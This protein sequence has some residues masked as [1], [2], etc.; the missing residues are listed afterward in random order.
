MRVFDYYPIYVFEQCLS[1]VPLEKKQH[2]TNAFL[3]FTALAFEITKILIL[4]NRTKITEDRGLI[5]SGRINVEIR[6]ND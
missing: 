6:E 2:A 3:G 4:L 1:F 5:T